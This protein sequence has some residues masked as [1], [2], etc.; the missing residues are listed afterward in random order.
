MTSK[1]MKLDKDK[2]QDVERAIEK[3]YSKQP[4]FIDKPE[5]F[6]MSVFNWVQAAYENEPPLSSDN[7]KR[8]EWLRDFWKLEPHLAG[9][10][11]SVI[12]IDKNRS[13]TLTGGRNQVMKYTR[14]LHNYEDGK[15]WRYGFCLASQSYY[16]SD[17]GAVV[18]IGRDGKAGPLRALYHTD[19]TKCVFTNN[20][21]FPLKYYP[22]NGKVQ[23][24]E[25]DD[26][27]SITS[28]PSTDEKKNGMGYC[29]ESRCLEL[30]KIMCAVYEHDKE[31][32]GSKAPK[33]L[34]LLGGIDQSEW[35][36]AMEARAQ[37]LKSMEREYFSNVAVLAN[38]NSADIDAKLIALSQLPD[39]FSLQEFT[40][41]LM[42]G[43]A[44]AFGYDPSEF[45][46]VQ[47]G[48]LGRGTE[49]EVQH[50]KATGKG[51]LDFVLGYQE[52]LQQELPDT[53]DFQFEQRDTQGE[54]IEAALNMAK[55]QLAID[56]YNTGLPQGMPLL[57]WEEARII[58][59][60]QGIIDQA[61]TAYEEDIQAEA[62]EDNV[63]S[64]KGVEE[65]IEGDGENE[66]VVRAM[67]KFPDE[68][69][70]RYHFPS[71]KIKTLSM[72]N[73]K[74]FLP[75]RKQKSRAGNAADEVV[76]EV[77]DVKITGKDID[78]ALADAKAVDAEFYELLTAKIDPGEEK[79]GGGE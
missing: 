42:Y 33:G 72:K 62:E 8:D 18:E 29:A 20:R 52:R 24:W 27:I 74:R 44:L 45:Y 60:E 34:L 31:K 35:N 67:M 54:G 12:A 53:L 2:L 64:K 76:Y 7:R 56:L 73:K 55:A 9:V 16:T 49:T 46:P 15:G 40:S 17:I 70:I 61:W 19:P 47:F 50:M 22:P 13:W 68:P 14:I 75:V 10:I 1:N 5:E 28:L 21:K 57:G 32:L 78:A 59:A 30:A 58:L 66:R 48:S 39:D 69:I 51:G 36:N 77:G 43:Y 37:R 25:P 63:D 65:D 41:F 3:T 79:N 4:R 23:K 38:S 11:N 71:G 26:F 6:F